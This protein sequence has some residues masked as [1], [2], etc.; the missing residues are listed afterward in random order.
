M[1]VI[2]IWLM[3]EVLCVWVS[4]DRESSAQWSWTRKVKLFLAFLYFSK[5]SLVNQAKIK[6]IFWETFCHTWTSWRGGR[7]DACPASPT[8]WWWWGERRG[9][10]P[11][12]FWRRTSSKCLHHHLQVNVRTW[13][14]FLKDIK[15]SQ[16]CETALTSEYWTLFLVFVFCRFSFCLSV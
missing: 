14:F 16:E 2:W 13:V 1:R 4:A 11:S 7:S 10:H 9:G 6:I 5:L 15:T 8:R 3:P 12:H